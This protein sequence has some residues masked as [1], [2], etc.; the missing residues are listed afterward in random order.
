MIKRNFVMD[1]IMI[2]LVFGVKLFRIDVN[3]GP[4]RRDLLLHSVSLLCM[5]IKK[6][7]FDLRVSDF[8]VPSCS[9]TH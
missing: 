7:F 2:Q 9:T 6:T 4:A 5:G 3:H 1:F 8:R